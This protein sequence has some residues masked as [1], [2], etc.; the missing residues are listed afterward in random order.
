MTQPYNP[1]ATASGVMG[2][3]YGFAS[4]ENPTPNYYPPNSKTPQ[5]AQTPSEYNQNVLM[6]PTGQTPTVGCNYITIMPWTGG[7]ANPSP[8]TS[9]ACK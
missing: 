9:A 8:V 2:M 1:I 3:G 4:D 7:A 5:V 6:T